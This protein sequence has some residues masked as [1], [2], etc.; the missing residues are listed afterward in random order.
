MGLNNFIVLCFIMVTY[1]L[2]EN[3]EELAK[4][5]GEPC[6][7][8]TLWSYPFDDRGGYEGP[9]FEGFNIATKLPPISDRY[10]GPIAEI[11]FLPINNRP[12]Y[13]T[14]GPS[15][16][17]IDPDL[18]NSYILTVRKFGPTSIY[19]TFSGSFENG[20]FKVH[21]PSDESS[22]ESSQ[23]SSLMDYLYQKTSIF[24]KQTES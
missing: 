14:S 20:S 16:I 3:V 6:L 22:R 21:Y 12:K 19:F 24:R 15:K 4:Q 1:D 8:R 2:P 11:T 5:I 7:T 10:S 17:F 9:L 18:L 13:E 23:I